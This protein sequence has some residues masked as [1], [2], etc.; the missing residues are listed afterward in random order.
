LIYIEPDQEAITAFIG[1]YPDATPIVMLNLLRF[2]AAADY[3][4]GAAEP[5]SGAEAYTRYGLA[6]EPLITASGGT[7]LWQGSQAG[8]LIGPQDKDWHLVV[9]VKYPSAR[10]F[11][12]M[13]SSD[14][15]RAVVFHRTAALEDSRL[16][17][18]REL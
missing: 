16:I 5:C 6:V 1:S 14:D 12:D 18:L 7:I 3:P 15:Y 13:V 10:A 2:R 11:L 9:L 17:A 4:A 8:M